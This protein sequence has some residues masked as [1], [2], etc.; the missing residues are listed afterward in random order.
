MLVLVQMVC[1]GF[2]YSPTFS[3]L[4]FSRVLHLLTPSPSTLPHL[5]ISACLDIYINCLWGIFS[6]AQQSLPTTFEDKHGIL[7][8]QL[9]RNTK[10]QKRIS[11]IWFEVSAY[12]WWLDLH[13]SGTVC[14][15]QEGRSEWQ[16][17][18]SGFDNNTQTDIGLWKQK[19]CGQ[20]A[21]PFP[22]S[23]NCNLRQRRLLENMRCKMLL[24]VGCKDQ[25]NLLTRCSDRK[26][27]L[28][29]T[30]SGVVHYVMLLCVEVDCAWLYTP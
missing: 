13:G 7:D 19:Y 22:S 14:L 5:A 9:P 15:H 10:S 6:Q 3:S 21:I 16:W 11:W 8:L 17:Q 1:T 30:L 20:N 29:T 4:A 18:W 26:G 12:E 28:M 27:H 24:K 2:I 25:A 23:E